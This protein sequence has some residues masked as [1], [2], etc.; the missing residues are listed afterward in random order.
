[1]SEFQ[2]VARVED[3]PENALLPV[4]V[5]GVRIVLA[6]SEGEIFALADQCSHEEF[7]LSDGDIVGGQ[8]ECILH[9]ARFDLKTGQA[10]ALPAVRP[11][12][13]YET[14]IQDGEIQVL[15]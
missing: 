13:A 4:E 1:M 9:G 6:N 14:R 3:V 2:T 11:V 15:L 5:D 8:V 10:K 7:P 12:K